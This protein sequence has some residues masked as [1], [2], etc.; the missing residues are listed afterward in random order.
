MMNLVYKKIKYTLIRSKRKTACIQIDADGQVLLRVPTGTRISQIESLIEQRKQWIFKHLSAWRAQH[1]KK[2][3]RRYLSGEPFPYLGKSYRLK[4]VKQQSAPLLLKAGTF[5]LRSDYRAIPSASDAFKTFYREKGLKQIQ[6]RVK[7]YQDIMSVKAGR[8]RM[9]ETKTR[10][11]SC[12][13]E[14]NLNF[15]WKCL[16]LPKRVLDYIVVHELAHMIQMNHSKKFWREVEKIISD[17][18]DRREWLRLNG[19][20]IEL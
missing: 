2:N 1:A 7:Y 9:V 11:A 17:Y 6:E 16:M 18:K 19:T 20:E 4:I 14:G 5:C 13:A 3:E 15:H 10:W 12:S 8:I